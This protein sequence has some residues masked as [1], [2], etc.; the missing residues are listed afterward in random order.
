LQPTTCSATY[1][2]TYSSY[3]SFDYHQY[4]ETLHPA[5]N[6][7]L[8]HGY[9]SWNIPYDEYAYTSSKV[10]QWHHAAQMPSDDSPRM[11]ISS[12]TCPV[13]GDHSLSSF[14]CVTIQQNINSPKQQILP[15][16]MVPLTS[17]DNSFVC[18]FDKLFFPETNNTD[19]VTKIRKP[20]K[21]AVKRRRIH[22]Q[23]KCETCGSIFSQRQTYHR[24]KLIHT[25]EKPFICPTCHVAF[26]DRSTRD[27]HLRI[28]TGLK[29]YT[30]E[31]CQKRFSQS[32]N[33]KR[34]VSA[35]HSGDR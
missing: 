19:L 4:L 30:C 1:D 7:F 32:G 2:F 16:Q 27:K 26:R 21:A 35:M 8:E 31:V 9:C 29:P 17:C 15:T 28:H 5:Y 11:Q 20:R 24:H 12:C 33:C 14:D 34:H 6:S 13:H 3:G 22:G 25:G 18:D 23:H 10:D